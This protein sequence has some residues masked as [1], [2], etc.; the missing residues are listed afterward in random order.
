MRTTVPGDTLAFIKNMSIVVLP[1]GGQPTLL[2]S[3]VD[4][5]FVSWSPDG[6]RL[7][8][9]AC[10]QELRV[11]D[12][13]SGIDRTV[14]VGGLAGHQLPGFSGDGQRV[15]A[16]AWTS[17]V[18][19]SQPTGLLDT[20]VGV[21]LTTGDMV[22]VPMPPPYGAQGGAPVPIRSVQG[23]RS[24][25]ELAWTAAPSPP[26]LV[27]FGSTGQVELRR[28][29]Y[30]PP[31]W[32]P[33]ADQ[34]IY[35]MPGRGL[36]LLDVATGNERILD[37]AGGMNPVWSPDGHRIAYMKMVSNTPTVYVIDAVT[38]TSARLVPEPA[39]SPT[40]SADGQWI[41]YERQARSGSGGYWN[42]LGLSEVRA[43]GSGTPTQLTPDDGSSAPVFAPLPPGP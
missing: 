41:A 6:Q 5:E 23:S 27:V 16:V 13:A 40:W 2:M 32:R 42:S 22:R 28:T 39:D 1:P 35:S 24:G 10:W 36:I 12:L 9:V 43:D 19:T 37:P 14:M 25:R 20:A 26:Q 38:A 30:G 8:Y 15:Y 18:S 4:A 31:V 11:L 33:T 3:D 34:L 21:D 29:G 17:Q 7:A